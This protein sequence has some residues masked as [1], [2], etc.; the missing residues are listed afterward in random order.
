MSDSCDPIH[1][2]PPGSL[3]PGILHA[4]TLEWVAI[5]LSNAWKWKV[6]VKSLSHVRLLVTPWT[7]RHW[8]Y[9]K[10]MHERCCPHH[11][12]GNSL[13]SGD[14]NQSVKYVNILS[15]CSV[16]CTY[17]VGRYSGGICVII[18]PLKRHSDHLELFSFLFFPFCFST[19][20]SFSL[21]TTSR[22]FFLMATIYP[23][24]TIRADYK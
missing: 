10:V 14:G 7:V 21:V 12:G 13:V 19:S 8:G 9:I 3:V 11:Y 15:S 24:C 17:F 23:L 6:K 16:F 20:V 4:R 18:K 22:F 5:S 2:S 1:C